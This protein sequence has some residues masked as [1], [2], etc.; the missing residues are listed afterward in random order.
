M[1]EKVSTGGGR[2]ILRQEGLEDLVVGRS[3]EAGIH[4]LK[5][6]VKSRSESESE[7]T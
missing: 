4:I 5:V 6:K 7:T 3:G 1:D 2:R